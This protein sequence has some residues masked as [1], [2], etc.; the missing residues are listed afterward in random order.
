M[1]LSR[2]MGKKYDPK[3]SR[4]EKKHKWNKKEEYG[5]YMKCL[6]ENIGCVAWIYAAT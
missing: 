6:K 2:I 5:V 4:K 1:G 3:K